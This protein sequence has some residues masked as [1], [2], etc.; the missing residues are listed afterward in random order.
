MNKAIN[1][2]LIFLLFPTML[3]TIFVGFD[4]PIESLRTSGQQVPYR[5]QVFLG[6]GLLLLTINL[7]RSV[8][9]WMGLRLV[10]QVKKFKWNQPMSKDRIYRVQ[11]YTIL[12]AVV[13]LFVG[14]VLYSICNE[15][16]L[17]AIAF[18]FCFADNLIFLFFGSRKKRFRMGI[19]SKAVVVAD[20]DVSVLYFSGLRKVSIH[21]QSI[22]FDYIKGLQLSFPIDCME[23]EQ[24]DAFFTVLE[25]QLDTDKVFITK[26]RN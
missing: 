22:Y 16:L 21:Q 18:W 15:A 25:E 1:V 9:R 14:T 8:T 26:L 11:V 17:P 13:M 3:F 10:N 23:K 5:F 12:E 19:T 4:L 2:L 20:R 24:H 7:K 6:I